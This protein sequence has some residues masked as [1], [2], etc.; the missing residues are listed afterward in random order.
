LNHGG[1]AAN[2]QLVLGKASWQLEGEPA[3]CFVTTQHITA[4]QQVCCMCGP[5]LQSEYL[6]AQYTVADAAQPVAKDHVCGMLHGCQHTHPMHTANTGDQ[7]NG[8]RSSAAAN[9]SSA[10]SLSTSQQ[11]PLSHDGVV[12][13]YCAAASI[14][15]CSHPLLQMQH[16]S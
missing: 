5:Q 15:T 4:G 9:I 14:N 13:K 6:S 11:A 7:N 8:D 3:V 10:G 1:A 16:M 2:G 12:L